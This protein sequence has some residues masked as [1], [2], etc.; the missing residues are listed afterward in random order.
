MILK[1]AWKNIWRNK[2][3][4]LVVITAIALGLIAGTFASS[5]VNGMMKQRV[6]T[7]VQMEMSHFQIHHKKFRDERLSKYYMADGNQILDTLEKDNRIVS[8]SARISG[9]AMFASANFSGAM[10][11]NGIDPIKENNTTGLKDRLVDGKYFEG[12]KRNPILVSK[13]T[14][15]KYHLKLRSKVVVTLQNIQGDMIAEAFRVVGIFDSKNGPI[16]KLNVYVK[17]ADLRRILK[18]EKQA[19]H[20]IAVLLNDHDLAE[21]VADEYQHKYPNLEV[22]SW[23]DLALGMR[24]M[25]D[26]GD[27]YTLILV[28]IILL[29]LMF[30]IIN[31][32]LMAVLER[33]KEL[34]MLMAIGMSKP[35]IFGMILLETV[36]LAMIGGPL[37][38]VASY[39]LISYFGSVGIDLS[40]ASY[41]DFGFSS[42]MYPFLNTIS[43]FK[44]ACMVIGMSIIAA[45]YPAVKALKLN[46]VESIRK[47]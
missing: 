12:I 37:G 41:E 14:A 32:M 19:Y 47:I 15:D 8:S 43:Y 42:M 24:M 28:G 11:I 21:S 23:L 9:N 29:A 27:T 46:P 38:L 34:G 16:D 18:L 2:I 36:F 26:I 10:R 5:I 30:S 20:E 6:N 17:D 4:S 3:R 31:T 45:I 25:V 44:I 33:V 22:K 13:T 39:L 7:V 35:K 1:I 40:A